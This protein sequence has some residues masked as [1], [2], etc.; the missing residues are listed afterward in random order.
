MAGKISKN[1]FFTNEIFLE[2]V[3]CS[4][5]SRGG[6]DS[7]GACVR[8]FVLPNIVR[9]CHSVCKS[10]INWKE[11]WGKR[12]MEELKFIEITFWEVQN[13]QLC[14]RE[15]AWNISLLVLSLSRY[16]H[17]LSKIQDKLRFGYSND[18]F[19]RKQSGLPFSGKI[20]K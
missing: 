13:P 12:L 14:L 7:Y 11:N 9:L 2:S 6:S 19:L 10:K 3:G 20:H 16:L 18:E 5:K 4:G 8:F 17:L 15:Y 1:L